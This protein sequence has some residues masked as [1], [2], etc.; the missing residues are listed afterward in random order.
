MKA[1]KYLIIIVITIFFSTFLNCTVVNA[2]QL[3]KYQ[4]T[5][6]C[7]YD[8][9]SIFTITYR[10]RYSANV[11]ETDKR[12]ETVINRDTYNIENAESQFTASTGGIEYVKIE[13]G[14]P[15]I[16]A[17]RCRPYV[18]LGQ[19]KSNANDD[20]ES[21]VTFIKFTGVKDDEFKEGDFEKGDSW[22]L[23]WQSA[24]GEQQ[25]NEHIKR[26]KLVAERINTKSQEPDEVLYF[27]KKTSTSSGADSHIAVKKFGNNGNYYVV[28]DGSNFATMIDAYDWNYL[29]G[30]EDNAV[31]YI[32][33]PSRVSSSN[34]SGN[35]YYSYNSIRFKICRSESDEC[36]YAYEKVLD[37]EAIKELEEEDLCQMMPDT[38]V[39]LRRVIGI[40]QLLVPLLMIVLCGLDLGKI[41]FSGDDL[42][43]EIPKQRKRFITRLIVGSL[44]F[45]VPLMVNLVLGMVKNSGGENTELIQTVECLF[46]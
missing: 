34:E 16:S 38:V 22:F 1:L 32:N 9:G 15:P 45:F 36:P 31:I 13:E 33:D 24:S 20:K 26:G 6:E 14:Y 3:D 11:T 7:V 5:Y 29:S 42:E 19:V 12:T 28:L 43:K 4:S 30:L 23:F 21:P 37:T 27:K 18:I 46:N 2:A 25:A 44:F 10:E 8:D 39:V 17:H 35:T 41:V 40:L